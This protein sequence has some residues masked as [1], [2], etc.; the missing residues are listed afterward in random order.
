MTC[1]LVSSLIPFSIVEIKLRQLSDIFF[2]P[3]NKSR[4]TIIKMRTMHSNQFAVCSSTRMIYQSSKRAVL[5]CINTVLSLFITI[6]DIRADNSFFRILFITSLCFSR[7]DYLSS[8]M[9]YNFMFPDCYSLS[10]S[11]AISSV[12]R[13][14]KHFKTRVDSIFSNLTLAFDV[15]LSALT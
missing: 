4:E 1:W 14:F 2:R 3:Q 11:H 15:A 9:A 6:Q 13:C 8:I 12:I 7:R 5:G 10:C